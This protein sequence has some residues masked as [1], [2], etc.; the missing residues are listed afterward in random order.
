MTIDARKEIESAEKRNRLAN[1]Y[2]LNLS[3]SQEF[4]QLDKRNMRLSK[5]N[6]SIKFQ[7]GEMLESVIDSIHFS[8]FSFALK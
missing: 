4:L 1:A 7:S 6:R 2:N 8:G 3:S 5:S